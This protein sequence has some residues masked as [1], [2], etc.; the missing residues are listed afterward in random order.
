[1]DD[2][3]AVTFF[4]ERLD[5][6]NYFDLTL[7]IDAAENLRLNLGVSNLFDKQPPLVA[8]PQQNGNGEQ[9][10]TLTTTYDVLGRAY[11]VSAR[12]RF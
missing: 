8:S 9:S 3:P 5:S 7:G 1:V 4:A 6:Q 11:F 2:L 10:N 12:L